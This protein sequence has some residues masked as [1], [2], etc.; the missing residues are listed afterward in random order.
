[1]IKS[2]LGQFYIGDPCYVLSEENYHNIWGNQHNFDYGTIE[3]DDNKEFIVHGTAYGDGSYEDQFGHVYG[4]DSGTLAVIP[5]ELVAKNDGL[6]Y[7]E[8]FEGKVADLNYYEDGVFT[9]QVG[10]KNII[11]NTGDEIIE[12]EEDEDWY[13]YSEDEENEDEYDYS[14]DEEYLESKHTSKHKKVCEAEEEEVSFQEIESRMYD[15]EDYDDLYSAAALIVDPSIRVPVEDLIS[16]CQNDGDDVETAYSIVTSDILDS[17]YNE[18]NVLN[19][20]DNLNESIIEFPTE[21]EKDEY[22]EDN[23]LDEEDYIDMGPYMIDELEQKEELNESSSP[24]INKLVQAFKDRYTADPDILQLQDDIR[25]IMWNTRDIYDQIVNTRT[26]NYKGPYMALLQ[27]CD[28]IGEDKFTST[29]VQSA[30]KELGLD[31]KEILAPLTDEVENY[32]QNELKESKNLKIESYEKEDVISQI[33]A[34]E[35]KNFNLLKEVLN[36]RK[37]L[38]LVDGYYFPEKAVEIIENTNTTYHINGYMDLTTSNI[39]LMV[40]DNDTIE[41]AITELYNDYKP[42]SAYT[43]AMNFLEVLSKLNLEVVNTEEVEEVKKH[44]SKINNSLKENKQLT[45]GRYEVWEK[46]FEEDGTTSTEYVQSFTDKDQ[47]Q[48]FVDGLNEDPNCSAYIV[49][50]KKITESRYIE[51]DSKQVDDIDGFTTD[52]TMYFDT[53]DNKYVFIFGDKDL[54]T[55]ETK[56]ADWEEENE[57]AAREWFDSY[58]GFNETYED[59]DDIDDETLSNVKQKLIEEEGIDTLEQLYNL[60]SVEASIEEVNE[61]LNEIDESEE[62]YITDSDVYDEVRLENDPLSEDE[63]EQYENEGLYVDEDVA[64]SSIKYI[65]DLNKPYYKE[66]NV[67]GNT[68]KLTYEIKDYYNGIIKVTDIELVD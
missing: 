48:K 59:L 28:D 10:D 52:Y 38:E 29:Q 60:V 54:Y 40:E 9:I 67:N 6:K 56:D 31:Y 65:L 19:L 53:E 4:V 34:E 44:V 45:E 24:V 17:Y 26:R 8:V 25:I 47:A 14:E 7:G 66:I 13:D 33:T 36:E 35:I 15:A 37:D 32:R 23:E 3:I 68:Y 30:L 61:L 42:E 63:V 18:E 50:S 41:E 39:L 11:I 12:D 22:I 21:Q 64:D 43:W 55:P 57:N 62:P 1:M 51:V 49:E 46:Y 58:E 27:L 20:S 2:E 16:T 5:L